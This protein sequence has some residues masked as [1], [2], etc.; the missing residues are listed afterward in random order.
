[1]QAHQ[2]LEVLNSKVHLA[3]LVLL[4]LRA[5]KVTLDLTDAQVRH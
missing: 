1:M 4:D 2:A 3:H 5:L